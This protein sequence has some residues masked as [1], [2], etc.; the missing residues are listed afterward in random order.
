MIWV[1]LIESKYSV[2]CVLPILEYMTTFVGE[3]CLFS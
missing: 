2:T 1:K 3:Y